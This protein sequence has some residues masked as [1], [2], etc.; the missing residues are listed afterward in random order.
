MSRSKS[1]SPPNTALV[2]SPLAATQVAPLTLRALTLVFGSCLFGCFSNFLQEYMQSFTNQE[3]T[4]LH[5]Q[6]VSVTAQG[7]AIIP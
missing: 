4:D 1:I 7:A 5:D 6:R 3:V 2:H